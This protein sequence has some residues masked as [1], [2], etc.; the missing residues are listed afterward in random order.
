MR[1]LP[2]R[3][4]NLEPGDHHLLELCT[5]FG[6]H[7]VE[8]LRPV[9]RNMRHTD[10]TDEGAASGDCPAFCD[11]YLLADGDQ[12]DEWE[13]EAEAAQEYEAEHAP[14]DDADAFSY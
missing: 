4:V 7:I 1:P 9:T 12:R 2:R 8:G 6:A 14:S 10:A 11:D 5:R 3:A 13:D